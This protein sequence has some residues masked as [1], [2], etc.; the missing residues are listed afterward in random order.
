MINYL[1]PWIREARSQ[2]VLATGLMGIKNC[3]IGFGI[4]SK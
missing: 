2:Q 1:R 4:K 3:T